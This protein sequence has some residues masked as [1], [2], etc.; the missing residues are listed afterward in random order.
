MSTQQGSSLDRGQIKDRLGDIKVEDRKE[1][2]R[3]FV[4][5]QS[6]EG[7][8][9]IMIIGPENME[10]DKSVDGFNRDKVRGQLTQSGF[11]NIEFTEQAKAVRG[12][13]DNDRAVLALSA[14]SGASSGVA[15]S[16]IPD[17]DRFKSALEK[18]GLSDRSEFKGKLVQARTLGGQHV[19]VIVGPEDFMGDGSVDLSATDLTKFQER[20]F[21][22]AKVVQDAK[23]VRGKL[24]DMAVI[25]LASQGIV[26]API[27]TGAVGGSSA[28]TTPTK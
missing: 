26:A 10:G 18:V 2:K 4:S 24:D 27:S 8:P 17:L 22:S 12:N 21:Q 7:H 16:S 11:K 28:G 15:Q 5:A 14:D 23:M 6:P 13:L 19:F 25:R 9:V 1:F 20:G 3:R